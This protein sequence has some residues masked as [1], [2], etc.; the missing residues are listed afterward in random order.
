MLLLR[1]CVYFS[2]ACTLNTLCSFAPLTPA[3][4]YLTWGRFTEGSRGRS[5][6][7]DSLPP[8]EPL[9]R[10]GWKWNDRAGGMTE[11]HNSHTC[12]PGVASWAQWEHCP[13]RAGT[14][15]VARRWKTR[16]RQR[17]FTP[18]VIKLWSTLPRDAVGTSGFK[19]QLDKFTK[20][21]FA[22]DCCILQMQLPPQGEMSPQTL[23]GRRACQASTT[24]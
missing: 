15:G 14:W 9:T 3:R 5:K 7:W 23:A 18:R 11:V 24:H 22:G 1:H 4:V 6:V 19:K 17:L 16:G 8:Q 13:H 21:R 10:I 2:R 20:P 12:V